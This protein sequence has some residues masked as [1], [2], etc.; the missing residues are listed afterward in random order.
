MNP[1]ALSTNVLSMLSSG[2]SAS[3]S[4][5]LSGTIGQVSETQDFSAIFQNSGTLQSFSEQL[6]TLLPEDL[7]ADLEALPEDLLQQLQM[8]F[9][10]G[11]VLPQAAEITPVLEAA[12]VSMEAAVRA[13]QDASAQLDGA[14]P[15]DQLLAGMLP[16]GQIADQARLAVG[17]QTEGLEGPDNSSVWNRLLQQQAFF[18]QAQATGNAVSEAD[19]ADPLA[20]QALQAAGLLQKHLQQDSAQQTTDR[21]NLI[22]EKIRAVGE[23]TPQLANEV[24]SLGQL[25]APAITGLAQDR[26]NATLGSSAMG[27]EGSST[28][29]GL[30]GL[31]GQASDLAGAQRFQGV[32][33]PALGM[34]H[35]AKGWDQ[36]L[37]DRVMWMVGRNI[38]QASL[39]IT[40]QHLGPIDIQLSMKDDVAHVS[41][42]T[43]NGAVKE[44]LEAAIPRLR[45]MFSDNNLQL[46]NVDVGQRGAQDQRALAQGFGGQGDQHTTPFSN[47][48][49]GA[50]G[51]PLDS[52][53]DGETVS[54]TTTLGLV[55][56]Y[57]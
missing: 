4:G 56:D 20:S 13:L 30:F 11:K 57:A 46:V 33:P 14:L 42:L 18:S 21:L 52:N 44:A 19:G 32:S 49:F 31:M 17:L 38:Q 7:S 22:A 8:L 39:R 6:R 28:S 23:A 16:A 1:A 9:S 53:G 47:E 2:N 12:T 40:P 24:K 45:D 54:R 36:A 48:Q 15:T 55:D 51:N 25:L 29:T 10:D 5:R 43:H 26:V 50:D 37:G 27:A 34:D 35:H 3:H 41:F